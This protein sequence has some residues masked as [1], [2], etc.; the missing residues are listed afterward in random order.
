MQPYFLPA[1]VY[2]HLVHAA[3]IFV[4]LDDV[5]FVTKRWTHRNRVAGPHG[6]QDFTLPLSGRS[7]NKH[8]SEIALHPEEFPRWRRKF[9]KR[10]VHQYG[11]AAHSTLIKEVSALL[12]RAERT[13]AP[14][15]LAALAA[16]SI[17]WAAGKMGFSPQWHRASQVDHDRSARGQE[18]ILSIC[19][20]L[21]A[22]DYVN[23]PGGQDLYSP[24]MFSARGIG[25]GFVES[26]ALV[27][28]SEPLSI[29]HTLLTGGPQGAARESADYRIIEK[30]RHE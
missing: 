9:T 23:A 13:A 30:A 18:K 7:Q 6:A 1:P 21:G 11:K 12:E 28:Q 8:L 19:E 17:D 4:F 25:L 5:Q 26:G 24:S 15:G 10:L 27:R 20:S 16:D 14:D 29:L 22:G 3:D 2:F